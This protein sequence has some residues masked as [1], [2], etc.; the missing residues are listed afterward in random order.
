MTSEPGFKTIVLRW[1]HR[2]SLIILIILA[3]IFSAAFAVTYFVLNTERGTQW[4]LQTTHHFLPALSFT[5]I[6][7][8][9]LHGVRIARIQW[10]DADVEVT[11][12]RIQLQLRFTDLLHGAI[13]LPTLHTAT[14]RIAP[15]GPGSDAAIKLPR[16][17][18]PFTLSTPDLAVQRLDIIDSGSTFTLHDLRSA[19]RWRATTLKLTQTQLHWNDIA[20]SANGD[21]GLRNDYPLSLRGKLS[22]PQWPDTITVNS[23]GNLR[24][25]ELQARSEKPSALTAQIKL[26]TLDKHLPLQIHAELLEPFAQTLRSE[27]ININK[28]TLDAD[29]DLEQIESKLTLA[30]SDSRYGDTHLEATANWH[31]EQLH[32]DAQW[33]PATGDLQ[34]HCDSALQK[35]IGITC[36]GNAMALPL[37]PWLAG[38]TAAIT[39]AITLEA[40]WLDPQWRLALALPS[41]SGKYNDDAFAGTLDLRTDD[42]AL[43]QLKQLA[44]TIGPNTI[45]A[46]G[47]FGSRYRLRANITATNLAHIDAQLGGN[48]SGSIALDGDSAPTLAAR[49]RGSQL[50]WRDVH[51]A[52]GA[53]DLTLAQLGK[54]H[55]HARIDIQQLARGDSSAADLTLDISGAE[56]QQRWTLNAALSKNSATLHCRSQADTKWRDWQFACGDFS[57]KIHANRR[58]EFTWRNTAAL[59][60]SAQF[61]QKHFELAP[62]CLRGDD[63]ELCLDQTLRF[64]GNKLQPLAAHASGLPLRWARAWFPDTVELLDDARASAQLQLRS[65]AP[66]DAHASM[67]IPTTHW[68]WR[69]YKT[70]ETAE[71]DAIH[72]EANANGQRA[73]I[74]TG[75]QSPSIG[76]IDAQLAINDP[77]GKRELDGH[78][79]IAQLQL[80]GIAWA[81][82]GL[83]NIGG[84]INGA[85]DITG[86][87]KTPR[88]HGQ[89]LLKDGS[90][91]W[92]PLG[93]P[94]RTVHA[95]LNFD[96]NSAKLGGWFALGAGGGDI[97]GTL[98]WDDTEK[99]WQLQLGLI[100]GGLSAMPLP[101]SNIVFSPHIQLNAV[102]QEVRIDG[103]VDIASAEIRLKE[104]PPETTDVS[105][106]Q[107][108]VGQHIDA[109]AWK[110][111]AKLGLNLGDQFHLAGFGADV[112]LSGRLQL[113]KVPGDNMHLYGEV[114]VPRGR[115]RAYGQRLTVRKGSVIFYGP[116]DNPDLN[117]EAVR[118]MPPGVTD[119]V[120]L[121][122]IGSLKTPEATLF[123][124]P[125]MPDSDIAYYLLSGHKPVTG[126]TGTNSYSASGALLSLGLAGS[127]NKAGQLAEK[128]GI[129]DLQL[130]TGQDTSGNSE[131]E[132]SGQLGKD[133]YVRYGRG[134]GQQSNSISF[135]YRL[136][137]KLMIE[138]ISGIED[139]LDLLYSFE[140]K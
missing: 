30:A 74:V 32:I 120:G 109:N 54:T 2:S 24:R 21:I 70:I 12:D 62:F 105:Q 68:R 34:L 116:L 42:G 67:R 84:E 41:I 26:A 139:A 19:V 17:F 80:S 76:R 75:A 132:V 20:L 101:D 98:H 27:H 104:L 15:Q 51:A 106:D 93:A 122:V 124:E 48:V 73:Q 49:L 64:A 113:D 3:L 85:I 69:T 22:L 95:D 133:L 96:N 77:R 129:T 46:N 9:L 1:L 82:E 81:F 16:L 59:R 111:W 11:L 72:V 103:Y 53:I 18:L 29:G 107:E 97:D 35:P 114:K 47:E 14:L 8:S 65:F 36:N 44:L 25:L 55:S 112:N 100:A 10:R 94:F 58:A 125:A 83:D 43:W 40:K 45:T 56:Q 52:T 7:G 118:D 50:H 102:P 28:A 57:G 137:P 61:T 110:M 123:S 79:A 66:L 99:N 60:G 126:A 63:I 117:L 31:D 6:E 135:Q 78:V 91:L 90:A 121:R 134:L 92:A 131:A 128:F 115:Y 37:T 4:A 119:V 89:L 87:A 130:G 38:E 39:S 136:T 108:I 23:K 127:E 5:R 13:Y 33:R 86:T 71:I 88:L 138:T 140:V